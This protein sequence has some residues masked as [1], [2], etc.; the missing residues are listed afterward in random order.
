[1]DSNSNELVRATQSDCLMTSFDR[2]KENGFLCDYSVNVGSKSFRVHRTVLAASS[3]YF[4]AMFSSNLKEVHDGHVNMKDVDQDGIAQCIEFMYKGKADLRM[5][6]IQHILQASHLLQMANLTEHCFNYLKTNISPVNCLS[7][8]NLA[9][10]YDCRDIKEQ[11]E[12][13]VM[14]NFKSVISSEMFPFVTKS[15]LLRYMRNR[16]YETA[17]KAVVTW[18]G[19]KDNIDVSDLVSIELFPF[20]FMLETILEE[21]IVKKNKTTEDSVITALFSNVKKLE[22]GLEIDN[23]FTLKNLAETHQVS[24]RIT[25]KNVIIRFLG[26]NFEHVIENKEFLDISKDDIMALFKSSNT[27]YRSETVKWEAMMKWVKHDVKNRRKTF[28]DLFSF[29][30]LKDL[31]LEFLKETVRI[32]PLVKKSEKCINMLIEEIFSRA[33]KV[34][35]QSETNKDKSSTEDSSWSQDHEAVADE[36]S[37]H[38]IPELGDTGAMPTY[39]PYQRQWTSMQYGDYG[40][41]ENEGQYFEPHVWGAMPMN[42]CSQRQVTPRSMNPRSQRQG[43]LEFMNLRSQRQVASISVNHRSQREATAM[44]CGWFSRAIKG[45]NYGDNYDLQD[46]E[47]SNE[48]TSPSRDN[49]VTDEAS[50]RDIPEPELRPRHTRDSSDERRV[51]YRFGNQRGRGG[52]RRR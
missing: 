8:I 45:V 42:T 37:A 36:A 25:V 18:A 17:W 43:I 4:E 9:Q 27:K 44:Q 39:S 47:S 13:V 7:V 14:S 1:M 31:P 26:A 50:A 35:P 33:S 16:T 11:A 38:D 20:K 10:M 5:E 29:L 46:D 34:V 24:D 28:Q 40:G 51:N 22:S 48:N 23:C 3:E 21:P 19:G 15:D 12:K 2:F 41:T 30:N 32:E 52:R 49:A 6:N